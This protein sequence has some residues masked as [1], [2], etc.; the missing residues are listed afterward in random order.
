[1]SWC[2]P[3]HQCDGTWHSAERPSDS[4]GP[5][6][7]PVIV[8][9]SPDVCVASIVC[10]RPVNY[11]FAGRLPC[12]RHVKDVVLFAS[13]VR[14]LLGYDI[15]Q[16]DAFV[17]RSKKLGYCRPETP[18]VAEL[19]EKADDDLF[20]H[21]NT[22]SHHVLYQF[23]PPK[24]AHSYN[25][26]PRHHTFSLIEQSTDLNH[27]DFFICMLYKYAY[28]TFVYWHLLNIIACIISAIYCWVVLVNS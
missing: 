6:Q 26:R 19:F 8:L 21:M 23:L 15:A 18:A 28:W 4:H 25:T 13:L 9:C 10:P 2:W 24:T 11:V 27:R 1:M 22:N 17:H 14:P 16:L 7:L 12:D 3:G 20:E 5:Y